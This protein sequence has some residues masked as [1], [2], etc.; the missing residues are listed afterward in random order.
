MLKV[1]KFPDIVC[2]APDHW[3]DLWRRRHQLM[4]RLARRHRVLFVEPPLSPLTPLRVPG[5]RL[6]W[7]QA[8]LGLREARPNLFVCPMI[9]VLPLAR[10][11]LIHRLDQA[12]LSRQ[13]RTAAQRLKIQNPILW[14][15]FRRGWKDT[16]ANL[17]E[18]SLVCYDCYD[19]YTGYATVS[20]DE[21]RH[22]NAW[23]RAVLG[24][25]DLVFAVSSPLQNHLAQ[26][27]SHVHLVPNAVDYEH[28]SQ[29]G[30]A[31]PVDIA[32]LPHPRIGYCGY[33]SHK[34]DFKILDTLAVKQPDWSLVLVGPVD[35]K[36]DHN[37]FR[38]FSKRPNVYLLGCKSVDALPSYMIQMDVC[39]MPFKQND[40]IRHSSPNKYYEYLA[41]GRPVVSVPID[42]VSPL[43]R[44]VYVANDTVDFIAS[45]KRA[46]AEDSPEN[47]RARRAMARQNTWDV[48]V[49]QIERL[50]AD[51][52]ARRGKSRAR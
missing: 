51:A 5:R 7:Q 42:D 41:A 20:T 43:P 3:S 13:L 21:A 28:F 24:Y 8:K 49:Q 38:R 6:A 1:T 10:F 48:R 44:A 15:Y 18:P 35:I 23:E 9:N 4:T 14:V 32:E 26:F 25:A 39:L 30:H 2:L 46:L 19:K 12:M 17:F 45:V 27:H 33:I 47:V 22:I 16:F 34:L 36:I 37:V 52:L 50:L 11:R 40:Q 31:E 29:L